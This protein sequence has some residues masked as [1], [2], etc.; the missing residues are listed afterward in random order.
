MVAVVGTAA[1]VL[2]VVAVTQVLDRTEAWDAATG[3]ETEEGV[4]EVSALPA[5]PDCS[6]DDALPGAE[7]R[8]LVFAFSVHEPTGESAPPPP[9]EGVIR[10]ESDVT[11]GRDEPY[12]ELDGERPHMVY[13]AG[14]EAVAGYALRWELDD[15]GAHGGRIVLYAADGQTPVGYYTSPDGVGYP[16][17]EN[18]QTYGIVGTGLAVEAPDLAQV[19]GDGCTSGY[20]PSWVVD[21]SAK[22]LAE[23]RADL[24]LPERYWEIDVT[25]ADGTTV[26]DTLT[27]SSTDA[28]GER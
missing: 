13:V 22:S 19:V 15:I 17:N 26:V 21:S 6:G 18:G 28:P 5:A 16:V 7:P 12:A 25:E 3:L 11:L 9:P 10:T 8:Y 20:V 24:D 1:S 27:F 23:S 14:E 2:G 4:R